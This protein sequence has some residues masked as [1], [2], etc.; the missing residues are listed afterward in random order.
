M[1]RPLVVAHG[2]LVALVAS[3]LQGAGVTTTDEFSR[4]LA[5]YAATVSETEPA[6][7]EILALWA[8]TISEMLPPKATH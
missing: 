2:K 6:E 5:I 3:V 7:G 4:L 1:D 8:Q